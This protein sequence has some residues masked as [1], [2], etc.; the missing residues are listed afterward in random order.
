MAMRIDNIHGDCMLEFCAY[1][2]AENCISVFHNDQYERSLDGNQK[3][4]SLWSS[5]WQCKPNNCYTNIAN[6][7]QAGVVNDYI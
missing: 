7:A 5:T 1:V 6:L 4:K 3:F 2:V